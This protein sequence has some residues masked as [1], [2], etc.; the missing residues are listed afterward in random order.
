M[1]TFKLFIGRLRYLPGGINS[2]KTYANSVV[3]PIEHRSETQELPWEHA[4]P[5]AEIPGPK[6]MFIIGNMMRFM[7]YIGEYGNMPLS[8]QMATLRNQ[9]GN[10]VKLDGI[11]GKRPAV[12]LYDPEQCKKMYR[13]EGTWPMRVAIETM[14]YYRERNPHFFKGKMG[15]VSSQGKVWHDFRKNVNQHMMQP[16]TIKPHVTQVDQVANDFIKR[17]RKLRDVKTLKLPSTFN[18]EMNKW[19]LES[20]CVIALDQRI[21]CLDSALPSNSEPQQMIN[22]VHEMFELFYKLEVSPSL[23]RLYDTRNLKKLFKTLDTINQIAKKHIDQAK[24][25]F[26]K[27][28]KNNADERCVLESLLNIDEQTAYIMAIDMLTAGIDTTANAAGSLLYYI[29]IN[30]RVQEK[31]REE[32]YNV[33]PDKTS[34]IT[35]DILNKIP[36][37]KACI[38]ET[39]RL[40]PIAIGNLRTMQTDT[41]LGGH[42]IP[43]GT[44]VIAAHSVIAQNPKYFSRSNDFI[45]ERWLKNNTLIEPTKEAH[46][47]AY[48]PFGFGPRT[49]IGR[50]FAELEIETL[51][52]KMIRNFHLEWPNKNPMEFQSRFINTLKS[53]LELKVIDVQ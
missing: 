41:V 31:L 22:A 27:F 46:S 37:L 34:S 33:L 21:G 53:P 23:W 38:K 30:P 43:K 6:S 5:F 26:K 39:L 8:E 9:Y 7:P 35:F 16:R 10:I 51:V 44:D 50:R 45:P 47:F 12:F 4:R 42:Q 32:V 2:A 25:R 20:I 3:C 24:I 52:L 28:P 14:K 36:Y 48:M 49:C 18:N 1:M 19:A 15:L 40:A 17:I 29:S 11:L 13:V